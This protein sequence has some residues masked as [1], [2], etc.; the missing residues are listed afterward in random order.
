MT[1]KE[2]KSRL[3]N[4]VKELELKFSA[5][6]ERCEINDRT[7][8]RR[9]DS[10]LFTLNYLLPYNALV[11]EYAEDTNAV[12]E[13]AFEDGDLFFLE[14]ADSEMMFQCMLREIQQ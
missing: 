5:L 13:N 11:I 10:S 14:D 9:K 3:E 7:C 8:F 4:R 6:Y 1:Q 12:Q 2:M